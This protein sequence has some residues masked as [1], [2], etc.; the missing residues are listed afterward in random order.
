MKINRIE[1]LGALNRVSPGLASK[2]IIEQT[3]TFVFQDEVVFTYNDRIAVSTPLDLGFEGAVEAEPLLKLLNRMTCEEVIVEAAE[4]EM[5][6]CAAKGSK[7]A[8]I[9]LQAEITLPLSEA[10][11]PKDE[12]WLDLPAT[13]LKGIRF[14]QFST[15]KDMNRPVLTC[16]CVHGR[17]ILSSDSCRLTRYDMGK[18]AARIFTKDLLIPADSVK[19][20]LDHKP[21]E[22]GIVG[23][24]IHFNN[25][26]DTILS[27]R[28]VEGEFPIDKAEP[29][30][31]V[32]GESIT[33]PEDLENLLGC[34]QVFASDD[35]KKDSVVEFTVKG[36]TMIIRSENESGWYEEEC[37]MPQKCGNFNF[38]IHPQM[39]LD[40]LDILENVQVSDSLIKLT[41]ENFEHVVALIAEK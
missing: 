12:D 39:L 18:K 30:L 11:M 3:D 28:M 25:E 15:G 14:A 23:T 22:Y 41:G 19:P 17:H 32:Q 16:V 9:K 20:I 27:L 8:G 2:A 5:T 31:S 38:M 13:F 1:L 4:G 26:E 37:A 6:L 10:G 7:K 35:F 36:K 29:L 33:F 40:L 21:I 34:A 24:W